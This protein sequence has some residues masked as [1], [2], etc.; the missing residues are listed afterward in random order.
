[1]KMR[2]SNDVNFG[3]ARIVGFIPHRSKRLSN[4][5]DLVVKG[6]GNLYIN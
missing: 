4:D 1:M 5:V 3:I 2:L 6:V